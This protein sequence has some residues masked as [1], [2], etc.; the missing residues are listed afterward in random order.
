[1]IHANLIHLGY[2]MWE[3]QAPAAD[4][5]PALPERTHDRA[6][7]R[8][9]QFDQDVWRRRVARMAE[10]GMNMVVLDLGD[11]VAWRSHPE[12]AVEGAWP[13]AKLRDELRRCRD[14]GLE[15]IPKLNFSATHDAW[16]GPYSRMLSTKRY[17]AVCRDLIAE[18][19][20]LFDGPRLFH[21]GMDEETAHHQRTYQYVVIRQGSLWWND[22]NF[23]IDE[24]QR[25]GPAAWVWS[26]K[27]WGMDAAT[28]ERTMPKSVVQSNWYYDADFAPADET[29]RRYV[30]AFAELDRMG[31]QQVPTGSNWASDDNYAGLVRHAREHLDASRIMGY[32]MTSWIPT[33]PAYEPRHERAIEIAAEALRTRQ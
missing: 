26:D 33:L 18:A 2:N 7:H 22:L 9:L 10:S 24:V 1:M 8:Q 17:Y 28:F 4:N 14:A 5:D 29:H 20:D 32:L 23:L 13:A 3:D 30:E 27:L 6:Y 21:L 11:G 31:Y 25:G 19:V 12:I 15:P 16:M